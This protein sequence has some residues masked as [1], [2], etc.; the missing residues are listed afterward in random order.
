MIKSRNM[1]TSPLMVIMLTI[2]MG[3]VIISCSDSTSENHDFERDVEVAT[4][5]D[6]HTKLEYIY[7]KSLVDKVHDP[8][9]LTGF[10]EYRSPNAELF[11]KFKTDP[12]FEIY[13]NQ[14][15]LE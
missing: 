8:E 13:V 5:I 9:N 1:V 15:K 4:V 2:I 11:E 10:P 14:E 3:A 7:P 6:E 12:M